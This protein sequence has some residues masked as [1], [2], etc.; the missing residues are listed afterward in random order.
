M[1]SRKLPGKSRVS[2]ACCAATS[3]G[4]C[5]QMLRIPVAIVI[6]SDASRYGAR[7]RERRRAAEPQR[8]VAERLEL[9]HDARARLVA[10]PDAEAA[11][12]G[13]Q[14]GR[15]GWERGLWPR[16]WQGPVLGL[17]G[18]LDLAERAQRAVERRAV[19]RGHH[20]RAQQRAARRHRGVQ[21]DVD[22]HAGV[23]ERAPQQHGLPVVLD[24]HGDDRRRL[25]R[26]DHAV[27]ERVQAVLEVARVLEHAGRTAAGRPPSARPAARRARRRPR[28][29]RPR[30]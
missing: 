5:C 4:S 24:Q 21:R 22:E 26:A 1:P 29:A 12:P 18:L 9:G 7:L 13:L 3:A 16:Q 20:A 2:S 15:A 25:R 27:A 17:E 6:S 11:E 10:A 14:R 23:V 19:V 30:R 28:R 8:V